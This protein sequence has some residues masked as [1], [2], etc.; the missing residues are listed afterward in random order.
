MESATRLRMFEPRICESKGLRHSGFFDSDVFNSEVGNAT[1][2][3]KEFGEGGQADPQN[4]W[5]GQPHDTVTRS[6][7]NSRDRSDAPD[8]GRG[9]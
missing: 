9:C 3:H 5:V 8:F 4:C 2:E 1:G 6:P 7:L